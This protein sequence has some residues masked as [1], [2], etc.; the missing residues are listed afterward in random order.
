MTI[1]WFNAKTKQ[2]AALV[3]VLMATVS[4]SA[5]AD[6]QNRM[7]RIGQEPQFT[8][9]KN[10]ATD[11]GYRAVSMPMPEQTVVTKEPNSLWSANR[12]TFFKDQR[13]GKV[14]D[15][16]TVLIEIEDEA[17]MQN[18]S[19]RSRAANEDT[20]LPNFLGLESQLSKVL[21]ESVDPANLVTLQSG[22]NSTGNAAIQ[23]EEEISLK[24]AAT[25]SQVLPNGNLV[26][27]GRQEVRVNYEVR[28]LQ[29]AGIIRPEDIMNTN[30]ISYEKIAEA[31]ISYGGRGHMSDV[32]KPRY[33]Q[34]FYDIVFPF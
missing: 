19:T 32:Q 13:A 2:K 33:G 12:Q 5:C 20:G 1:G 18:R 24:V 7:S 10:P 21:P 3:A 9:I 28:E 30:T 23:R 14:G 22:S 11:P 16:L 27:F 31:R 6:M 4:L 15:I 26:I 17:D 25:V 34:E 8:E 29:I